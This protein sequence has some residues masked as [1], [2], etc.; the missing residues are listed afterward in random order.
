MYTPSSR[1]TGRLMKRCGHS[2]QRRSRHL[3][4]CSNHACYA[5]QAASQAGRSEPTQARTPA[6][7]RRR[8]PPGP[9]HPPRCSCGMSRGAPQ[10]WPHPRQPPSPLPGACIL[11]SQIYTLLEAPVTTNIACRTVACHR[12]NTTTQQVSNVCP[13]LEEPALAVASCRPLQHVGKP[14][15]ANASGKH[16]EGAAPGRRC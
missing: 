11:D 5:R 6:C 12:K 10:C 16:A 2:L 7:R 14:E 8:R 3:R 9:W 4:Q 1:C 13:R 15:A